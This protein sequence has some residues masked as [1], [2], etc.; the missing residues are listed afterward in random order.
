MNVKS[1]IIKNIP[2]QLLLQYIDRYEKHLNNISDLIYNNKLVE[3]EDYIK[4]VL[5]FIKIDNIDKE[6]HP[7]YSDLCMYQSLIKTKMILKQ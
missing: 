7:A 1:Q 5:Q 4:E 2:I 3:A 6:N